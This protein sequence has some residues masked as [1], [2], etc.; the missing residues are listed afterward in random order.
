MKVL[1]ALSLMSVVL[2]G[3]APAALAQESVEDETLPRPAKDQPS[4]Y[5]AA[6]AKVEWSYGFYEAAE[7]LQLKALAVEERRA[8]KERLSF[9]LFDRVY[10][11]AEWWDKAAAEI[12]RTMSFVENDNIAQRRKYMMDLVMVLDKAGNADEYIDALEA[13][14]RMSRNEDERQRSL[15]ALHFALKKL[16]R[17]E[18]RV[19]EYEARVKEN[20]EDELM[21]RILAEIY[22]GSGLLELP[23]KAI[24]KYEQI[25]AFDPDNV[26]ACEQLARLYVSAA[27]PD[28]SIA[29]Y[30]RLLS[31]DAKRFEAHFTGGI[32]VIL[33]NHD[34]TTALEW[35][36]KMAKQYPD[37]PEIAV[38]IATIRTGQ[39]KYAEAAEHY[40]KAVCLTED[41]TTKL[42]LYLRL[43][44]SRMLARQYAEAERNCR[45]A[46]QFDIRSQD[47]RKRFQVLL[48]EAVDGQRKAEGE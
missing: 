29:M 12:R 28:E 5:Y 11:R 22:H 39:G 6:L 9:D 40:Q 33:E 30:E 24:E 21:L 16:Q 4:D 13:V 18:L 43:I 27:Q 42:S 10:C 23:G 48:K 35:A 32:N 45:E 17:L 7:K 38:R 46:L 44:D 1:L 37:S 14:L 3:A 47:L 20:P 36:D 8:E 41:R 26:N 2:A 15:D 31:I 19:A 34:E 25:R